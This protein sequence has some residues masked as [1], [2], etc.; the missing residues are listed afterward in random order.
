[1]LNQWGVGSLNLLSKCQFRLS[2][3]IGSHHLPAVVFI[4]VFHLQLAVPECPHIE[5][6]TSM[7]ELCGNPA[8]RGS[9]HWAFCGQVVCYRGYMKLMGIGK[10][11]FSVL[12]TAA[13]KGETNCPYD[14]RYVPRGQQVPSEKR[15]RIHQFLLELYEDVAEFIP[16]G[17]NSNKRPRHGELKIDPGNISEIRHLPAASI[18]DYF[19]QCK[20]S[21][22]DESISR[23]LF[24][25][26]S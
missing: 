13:R 14:G 3:S 24:C 10:N 2:H 7:K 11:R 19:R 15:S 22:N 18:S 1:M 21:L 26:V 8:C 20:S 9:R 5:V 17:L 12:S 6:F 16:D 4:T 25:R 23:K